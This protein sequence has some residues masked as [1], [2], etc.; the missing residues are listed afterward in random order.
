MCETSPGRHPLFLICSPPVP[1]HSRD[2]SPGYL[3]EW[4]KQ[5]RPTSRCDSA[6]HG[7]MTLTAASTTAAACWQWGVKFKVSSQW[8]ARETNRLRKRGKVVGI[9]T[10]WAHSSRRYGWQTRLSWRFVSTDHYS[11][12]ISRK[13]L[14]YAHIAKNLINDPISLCLV[15]LLY[16]QAK[17]FLWLSSINAI[18]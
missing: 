12:R 17:L 7:I 14:A 3:R 8:R 6:R 18:W 9:I 13:N 1:A 11:A 16:Q 10:R 15:W 5:A 4:D 2:C